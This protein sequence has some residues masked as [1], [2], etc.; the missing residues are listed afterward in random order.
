VTESV[1]VPVMTETLPL[2]G[3]RER[4]ATMVGLAT[5]GQY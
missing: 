4:D 2:A 1:D 5:A 3:A